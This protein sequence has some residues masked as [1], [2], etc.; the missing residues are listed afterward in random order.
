MKNINIVED[1]HKGI[2]LKELA[3][4]DKNTT[5]ESKGEEKDERNAE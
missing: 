4:K 2:D 1:L 3:P 5:K